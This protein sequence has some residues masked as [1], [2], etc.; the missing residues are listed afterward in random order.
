MRHYRYFGYVVHA[1]LSHVPPAQTIASTWLTHSKYFHGHHHCFFLVRCS[2]IAARSCFSCLTQCLQGRVQGCNV[3]CSWNFSNDHLIEMLPGQEAQLATN[4]QYSASKTLRCKSYLFVTVQQLRYNLT[5][6][7][8]STF[9]QKEHIT[10]C[11]FG[12]IPYDDKGQPTQADS[13]PNCWIIR[14]PLQS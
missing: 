14:L 13:S 8:V 5:A 2:A 3:E 7:G 1:P 11:R 12:S 9:L 6:V 4:K 10:C